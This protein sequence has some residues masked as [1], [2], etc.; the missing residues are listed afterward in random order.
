MVRLASKIPK[1]IRGSY[2]NHKLLNKLKIRIFDCVL[3]L[4]EMG[5]TNRLKNYII[6]SL[7]VD[8]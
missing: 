2:L 8:I 3:R 7:R 5:R 1:T 6:D 4:L